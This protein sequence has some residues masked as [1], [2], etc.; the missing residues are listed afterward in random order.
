MSHAPRTPPRW[1]CVVGA[2]RFSDLPNPPT[3]FITFVGFRVFICLSSALLSNSCLNPSPCYF[4]GSRF[5][6][7][8]LGVFIAWAKGLKPLRFPS[9]RFERPRN[10]FSVHTL[11]GIGHFCLRPGY[12]TP[13]RGLPT[14]TTAFLKANFDRSFWSCHGLQDASR[15]LNPKS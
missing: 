15:I 11:P 9:A 13:P 3:H 4:I 10:R 14:L 12:P 2:P 6:L 7:W 1:A 8:D 5:V